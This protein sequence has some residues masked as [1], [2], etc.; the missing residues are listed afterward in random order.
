MTNTAQVLIAIPELAKWLDK[1]GEF[2]QTQAPLLA[3]D[4]VGTKIV[5]SIFFLS[6]GFILAAISIAVLI[7]L[8]KKNKF[9]DDHIPECVFSIVGVIVGLPMVILN[10]Y[11]LIIAC[12]YP[13]VVV[14]HA[15]NLFR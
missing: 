5:T 14:L 11:T 9:D 1:G 7:W 8:I 2:I 6:I 4:I 10:T 12:M 15:L 3:Q 13:K